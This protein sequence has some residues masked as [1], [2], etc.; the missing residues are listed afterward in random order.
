M[1]YQ[2]LLGS[3]LIAATVVIHALGTISAIPYLKRGAR[4]AMG[5]RGNARRVEFVIMIV[6]WLFFLHTAQIWLW[7]SCYYYLSKLPDFET[8]LYF[9]TVSYTTL[10]YGDIVLDNQ[11]RLLSAIQAANGILLFGWS[12]AFLFGV[13][14]RVWEAELTESTDS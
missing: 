14:R 11:W 1:I 9:S 6:L 10:G 7:A 4:F 12:T 5:S 3:T 2:L 8:A 13:V